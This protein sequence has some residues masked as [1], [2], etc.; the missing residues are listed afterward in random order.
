MSWE[1]RIGIGYDAHRFVEGRPLI[2]GGI[3]IP[4]P[5][6]LAGHYD[7]DVLIHAIGDAVLGAIGQGDLGRHFPDTDPT[8]AGI[9]SRKILAAIAGMMAAAA[10]RPVNVD[11]VIIAQE[12]KLAPFMDRMRESIGDILGLPPGDVGLKATTTEHMGFT[13]RKEGLAA[14]AVVLLRREGAVA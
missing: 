13:G 6:G 10:C 1:M 14:M 7:A 4:H 3:E 12:P 2:L 9:S 11:A 5:R 8:L